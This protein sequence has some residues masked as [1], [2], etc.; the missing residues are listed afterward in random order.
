MF[1]SKCT[2]CGVDSHTSEKCG[3]R[4]ARCRK[5]GKSGHYARVCKTTHVRLLVE[6]D[7]LQETIKPG[8]K[9]LADNEQLCDAV[10]SDLYGIYMRIK[11]KVNCNMTPT[12]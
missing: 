1:N 2:R 11:K 8:T 9:N 3:A 5:C 4:N 10:D 6:P 12:L 7:N